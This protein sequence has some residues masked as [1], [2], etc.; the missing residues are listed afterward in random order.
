M[1]ALTIS[2]AGCLKQSIIH[3]HVDNLAE[4]IE[5]QLF[6][7]K[8]LNGA[9]SLTVAERILSFASAKVVHVDNCFELNYVLGK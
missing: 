2:A 5:R 9:E 8:P 7:F 1:K 4:S 3:L 6:V